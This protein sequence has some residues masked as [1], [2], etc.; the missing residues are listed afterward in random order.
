M[1]MFEDVMTVEDGGGDEKVRAI[2][3]QRM[4]NRGSW[5][6]Q[7]SFGRA[8]MAAIEAGDVMLGRFEA[9]DAYGN[10]IPSRGMVEPGTKGSRE[11]V[12]E[13]RGEDWAEMMEAV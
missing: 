7:G 9:Y 12:A 4:V 13:A 10:M 8:M 3:I 2:A 11:F 6:F 1:S 5:S